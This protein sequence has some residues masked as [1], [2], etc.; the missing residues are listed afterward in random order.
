MS[1]AHWTS[2]YD[3]A[4]DSAGLLL[5]ALG[6]AVLISVI[7]L[8]ILLLRLARVQLTLAQESPRLRSESSSALMQV[9]DVGRKVERLTTVP[10]R[11]WLRH[12]AISLRVD[13][14]MVLPSVV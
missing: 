12:S 7:A 11:R 10:S 3:F 6:R 5:P 4:L 1:V 13:A 2:L 14:D 9:V 8:E